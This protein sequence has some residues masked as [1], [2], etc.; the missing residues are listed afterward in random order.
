MGRVVVHRHA[1]LGVVVGH[2]LG[3]AARPTRSASAVAGPA[4][5]APPLRPAC[6]ARGPV[7]HVAPQR[8]ALG[9]AWVVEVAVGVAHHA[10]ALHDRLRAGVQRRGEGD[11]LV[12]A[13]LPEAVGAARPAPPRWRTRAPSGPGAAATRPPRPARRAAPLAPGAAPPCPRRARRPATSTAHSPQ[14]S[15]AISVVDVVH[16][17]VALGPRRRRAEGLDDQGMG[18]QLE[19]GRPVHVGERSQDQAGGDAPSARSPPSL[20]PLRLARRSR[21]PSGSRPCPRASAGCCATNTTSL[22]SL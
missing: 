17:G 8:A 19:E 20:G 4:L 12:Q 10:D 2:H 6:D 7:E 9:Q 21:P 11:D 13:R 1:P 16:H 22:G 3:I 14:P 15:R 5:M 18:V